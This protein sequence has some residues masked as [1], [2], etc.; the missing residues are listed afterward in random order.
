MGRNSTIRT[1]ALGLLTSSVISTTAVAGG[2]DRGGVNIDQLFDRDR[3]SASARITYVNPQRTINNITRPGPVPGNGS[4]IDIDG[5]F[6]VPRFGVKTSVTDNVDCLASYSEPYGGDSNF[7]TG[8]IFSPSTS[9]FFLDTQDYGLTCSY[10]FGAGDTSLGDSYIRIIGGGSYMEAQGFLSRQ[11]F[12]FGSGALGVA[13]LT[14]FGLGTFDITDETVGWRAGLAYEIPAIALNATV[15]YSSRYDLDFTGIQDNTGF[16][17]LTAPQLAG[18][19]GPTIPIALGGAEIP[20]ALDVKLQSGIN[21]TTLAFLNL[22]WQDWDQ[23]QILPV[24][25]TTTGAATGSTLDASFR[26]GYTATVG[27]GKELSEKLSTL[28]SLTWDRGTATIVG[29]Q[30]DTWTLAG[31]LRY[32]EGEHFRLSLG[33]AIG[34]LE[35]GNSQINPANPDPSGAITYT[36][37]ADIVYA[38]TASAKVRW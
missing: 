16:T 22:R 20:Q 8:N 9:E 10:Q 18:I 38:L 37:D 30:S 1:V 27:I 12:L 11:S 33:G 2:F 32:K 36:F 6:F 17:T 15:L 13:P 7:G 3:L 4:S 29:T 21:Q 34:I 19:G 31:G 28:T 25:N 14:E 26:D 24:I 35:G 5:D 23:L